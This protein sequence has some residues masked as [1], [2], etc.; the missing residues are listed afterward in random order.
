MNLHFY[1]RYDN[2][3][4]FFKTKDFQK[5]QKNK[6]NSRVKKTSAKVFIMMVWL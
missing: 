6:T 2:K 3:Q 1:K 5:M 4:V